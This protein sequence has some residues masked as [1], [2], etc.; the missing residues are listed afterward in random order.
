MKQSKKFLTGILIIYQTK[1]NY[2][3]QTC[4][5]NTKNKVIIKSLYF[6]IEINLSISVF[7]VYIINN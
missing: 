5:L 2:T 6:L 4:D 1:N 3:P 7:L